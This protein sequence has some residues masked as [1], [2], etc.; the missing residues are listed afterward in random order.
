MRLSLLL[1]FWPRRKACLMSPAWLGHISHAEFQ[2]F[3]CSL[4][5]YK[6]LELTSALLHF[7]NDYSFSCS[8]QADLLLSTYVC[9]SRI[10]PLSLWNVPCCLHDKN[11]KAKG[12]RDLIEFNF[13]SITN[14]ALL[15]IFGCYLERWDYPGPRSGLWYRLWISP[16]SQSREVASKA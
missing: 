14:A 9:F 16:N 4:I 5:E 13:A 10:Y 6:E 8:S 1:V 3:S 12:K 2:W 11:M 15:R 7:Q